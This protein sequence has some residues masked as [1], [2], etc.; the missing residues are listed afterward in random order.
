MRA[1]QILADALLDEVEWGFDKTPFKRS[2]PPSQS[3]VP[4]VIPTTVVIAYGEGL[5]PEGRY[6]SGTSVPEALSRIIPSIK[7]LQ[8]GHRDPIEAVVMSGY[9][10]MAREGDVVAFYGTRPQAIDDKAADMLGLKPETN[11]QQYLDG[12]K[13]P[14][15]TFSGK[16]FLSKARATPA[17]PAI[18]PKP[19]ITRTTNPP[20]IKPAPKQKGWP[21]KVP[22][23]EEFLKTVR[24]GP[25]IAYTAQQPA[26]AA[27]L[28]R[29]LPQYQARQA[30]QRAAEQQRAAAQE[31][32]HQKYLKAKAAG[33]IPKKPAGR[34]Q[35]WFRRHFQ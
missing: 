10:F 27:D 15:A 25:G 11:V 8:P 32:L 4:P 26:K 29:T 20:A 28:E 9:R 24:P 33:L 21:E 35:R 6:A 1:A 2:P 22:G 5:P 23:E 17:K 18:Q 3:S 16:Q 19:P 31:T 12:T 34:A 30:Q 14:Y 13:Q 7:G